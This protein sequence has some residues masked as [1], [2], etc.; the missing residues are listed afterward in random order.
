MK[1]TDYLRVEHQ[2]Q[3]HL[4]SNR[5]MPHLTNMSDAPEEVL[6]SS[7]GPG[8]SILVKISDINS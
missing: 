8:K 5:L 1:Q 7:H 4:L 3:N 2:L 6:I